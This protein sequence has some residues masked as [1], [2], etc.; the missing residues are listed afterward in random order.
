MLQRPVGLSLLALALVLVGL[1][2]W[3]LLPVAP[4]P[5]VEVPMIVVTAS[6]PGASP[7]SMATTVATPRRSL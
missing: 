5:Q 6:L 7:E 2:C 3:R 4:L 1:L